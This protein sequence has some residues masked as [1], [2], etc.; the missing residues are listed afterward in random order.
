MG[1]NNRSVGLG[2]LQPLRARCRQSGRRTAATT[3]AVLAIGTS[4]EDEAVIA[5][6]VLLA[7]GSQAVGVPVFD[8][9]AISSATILFLDSEASA[10]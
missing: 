10:G 3:G 8:S 6:I 9:L 4:G 1:W 7:L 2:P 5:Y